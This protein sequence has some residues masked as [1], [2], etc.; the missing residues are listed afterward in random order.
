MSIPIWCAAFCLYVTSFVQYMILK[1]AAKKFACAAHEAKNEGQA[2]M[3]QPSIFSGGALHQYLMQ[4]VH[5]GESR[6]SQKRNTSI[7]KL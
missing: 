5:L 2:D 1:C 6:T 7:E 4:W 3:R